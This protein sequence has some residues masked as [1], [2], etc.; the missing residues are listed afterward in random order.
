MKLICR[1]TAQ[2]AALHVHDVRTV[3]SSM[4]VQKLMYRVFIVLQLLCSKFIF[5]MYNVGTLQ[6][7][8]PT[9]KLASFSG[10][11]TIFIHAY[12]YWY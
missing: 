1:Q 5:Y 9:Y 8:L 2:P 6:T 10:A 12:N 7:V 11:Q 3:L 4:L